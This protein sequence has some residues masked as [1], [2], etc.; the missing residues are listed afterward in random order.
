MKEFKYVAAQQNGQRIEGKQKAERASE[1]VDYLHQKGL[2]VISV[3]E[4]LGVDFSKLG[5]FQIGGIP[6]KEKMLLT[7]QLSVMLGAGVPLTQSLE[8]LVSQANNKA[9]KEELRGVYKDVQGGLQLSKA[10]RK[11]TSVFDELQIN[12]IEAGEKSGNLVEVLEQIKTDLEK[13]NELR[14]KIRGAMIYPAIVFFVLAIVIV[15]MV[16]FMIPAVEGLY[17]DF[18]VSAAD[19]PAVTRLMISISEFVTNPFGGGS[20]IA[21]IFGSIIGYRFY[22][23]SKPGRRV[24]DRLL[25]KVPVFGQIFEYSQVVQM[26]RLLSMLLKSGLS[27]ID[28][29]QTVAKALGNIHYKMALQNAVVDVSKG[30]PLATSLSKSDVIPQIVLKMIA[31][32]EDTGSLDDMLSDMAKYYDDELNNLAEN[33]TKLMEPVILLVVGGIVGVLALAIYLPIYQIAS[34]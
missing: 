24:I 29:L 31:I 1:V 13:R 5:S 33:L 27:I 34:F 11:N 25:L 2:V 17:E 10:F 7:K 26:T 4:T 21:V 32:G 28:A 8:V 23:S 12:L 6:L 19:L 3:E 16:V 18:G 9:F 22:Y 15:V 20:L 14:S 30:T